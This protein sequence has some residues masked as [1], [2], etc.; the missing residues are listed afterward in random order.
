MYLNLQKP[1]EQIQFSS[2]EDQ[3]NNIVHTCTKLNH[4]L[5]Q[6]S[7]LISEKVKLT[8]KVHAASIEASGLPHLSVFEMALT[9][10]LSS[11]KKNLEDQEQIRGLQNIT[12]MLDLHPKWNKKQHIFFE[13]M[14][15][16]LEIILYLFNSAI[17]NIF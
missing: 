2:P 13:W 12:T 1:L 5:K 7:E 15:Q 10:R 11:Q 9:K 16:L 3:M 8:T 17:L 4:N 6:I 14:V